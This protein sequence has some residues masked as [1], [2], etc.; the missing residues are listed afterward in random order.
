MKKKKGQ[1]AVQGKLQ[2]EK[3]KTGGSKKERGRK[4]ERTQKEKE[5]GMDLYIVEILQIS[6]MAKTQRRG[7]KRKKDRNQSLGVFHTLYNPSNSSLLPSFLSSFLYPPS[8]L[9]AFFISSSPLFSLLTFRF[10]ITI[11]KRGEFKIY[12]YHLSFFFKKNNFSFFPPPVITIKIKIIKRE[13]E[14][15]RE[16]KRKITTHNI[17]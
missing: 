8:S 16:R 3:T 12:Y 1:S 13:R 2:R 11:P 4:K 17:A 7:N 14:R 5:M 9:N 15:E 10:S 6:P